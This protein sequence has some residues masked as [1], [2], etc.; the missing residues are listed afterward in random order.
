MTGRSR[1]RERC[2][3]GAWL[4]I[5]CDGAARGNPGPA[6]IGGIAK[7]EQGAVIVEVS[8]FLGETTNNVAEYNA[9]IRIL[10]ECSG[11]GYECVR[12][13]TDSELMANQ[14]TGGFKVKSGALRPL[15]AGVKALLDGYREVQVEHIPREKNI[16]C[17]RLANVAIDEGLAGLRRP[18]LETGGE[19]QLFD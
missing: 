5:Y 18:I 16:E 10:E 17:D 1:K 9:L 7:N 11:R 13:Y 19:N 6:G 3:A 14:I 15:H 2:G 4:H 8:E 12:I